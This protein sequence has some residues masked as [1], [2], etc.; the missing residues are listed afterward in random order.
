MIKYLTHKY[1]PR[2]IAN[3]IVRILTSYRKLRPIIG[4]HSKPTTW[5]PYSFTYCVGCKKW[6]RKNHY[7]RSKLIGTGLRGIKKPKIRYQFK[8]H[9]TIPDIIDYRP[10]FNEA[11]YYPPDQGSQGSCTSQCGI[12]DKAFQEIINKTFKE[13]FS[14]AMLYWDIRDIDGVTDS[15]AGGWMDQI[16]GGLGGAMK[17][18]KV[19]DKLGV[20]H[21]STMPYNQFDYN[22][23][24]SSNAYI[25]A[26]NYKC[27]LQ[28]ESLVIDDIPEFL[29]E[30]KL[31]RIGIPITTSF[32]QSLHNGGYVPE[33]HDDNIRGYHAVLV[34]GKT[35]EHLI[36]MNS[37]GPN[38]QAKGYFYYPWGEVRY[39]QSK[40]RV[41][42]WSQRDS[43]DPSP[44]P[45]PDPEPDPDPSPS[46]LPDNIWKGWSG[47]TFF[48][49]V[50]AL[51]GAMFGTAYLQFT[52]M[53]P[54]AMSYIPYVINYWAVIV[55]MI[56]GVELGKNLAYKY[57]LK[58]LMGE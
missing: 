19:R 35:P 12:N 17:G 51:V 54:G 39:Q 26:K 6:V 8:S 33:T 40:G 18:I 25:E 49:L 55:S 38:V 53:M 13:K 29:V 7:C 4:L 31:V 45:D 46:P 23:R 58:K 16:G 43:N 15:D 37:W 52:G 36:V 10:I 57:Y 42:C 20:C 30:K 1:L 11:G 24:P 9:K 48:F 28:Q 50:V 44:N 41:D 21:N 34:V 2:R 3:I 47:A 32:N 56:W 22:T 27:N 5:I 14:A